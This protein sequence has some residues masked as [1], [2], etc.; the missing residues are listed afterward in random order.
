MLQKCRLWNYVVTH[1]H[2]YNPNKSNL[3]RISIQQLVRSWKWITSAGHKCL[4]VHFEGWRTELPS[5][6][7]KSFMTLQCRGPHSAR[8]A[9]TNLCLHSDSKHTHTTR[10]TVL[11]PALKSASADSN[12]KCPSRQAHTVTLSQSVFICVSLL[13]LHTPVCSATLRG[14]INEICLNL[15]LAPIAPF[16]AQHSLQHW[17]ALFSYSWALQ[18]V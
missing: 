5:P 14:S 15:V 10:L 3:F 4:C 13:L 12:Y 18:R 16:S 9:S 8:P 17:S 1:N 6:A 7:I 2:K 11:S